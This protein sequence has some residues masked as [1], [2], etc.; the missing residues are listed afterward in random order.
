MRAR[1]A[2]HSS[3]KA[4]S[5]NAQEQ[6]M[7]PA[8]HIPPSHF[9][10]SH[11]TPL[12]LPLCR[13]LFLDEFTAL[14]KDVIDPD[15]LDPQVRKRN[16]TRLILPVL[17]NSSPLPSHSHQANM[18]KLMIRSEETERKVTE[19]REGFDKRLQRIESMLTLLLASQDGSEQSD[20][21][22][23]TELAA[24]AALAGAP[25][26]VGGGDES[27]SANGGD[28]DASGSRDASPVLASA[29]GAPAKTSARGSGGSARGGVS[30]VEARKILSAK[31]SSRS[32][33]VA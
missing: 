1:A 28:A 16:Q 33:L 8:Q 2:A 21:P 25:L 5:S 7:L 19:I 31:P 29:R 30:S 12:A 9:P 26:P 23:L 6:R 22:S 15:S 10:P 20:G 32:T 13:W 4:Q 18:R 3:S 27:M 24:R 11:A 17:H 14:K